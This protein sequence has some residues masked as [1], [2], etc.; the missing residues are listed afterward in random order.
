ME[1]EKILEMLNAELER[2]GKVLNG[3]N[4]NSEEYKKILGELK[5]LHG[6]RRVEIERASGILERDLK[7]TQMEDQRDHSKEVEKLEREKLEFEKSKAQKNYYYEDKKIERDN[8]RYHYDKKKD[9]YDR[10]FAHV[11]RALT[12]LGI[13]VPSLTYGGLY[14]KGLEFETE[15]TVTSTMF[16]SLLSKGRL[17]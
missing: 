11:D 1:N 8:S 16:R 14:L 6:L 10:K 4:P 9:A 3:L 2:L 15:G 7:V 17:R 5:D 13:L 12:A